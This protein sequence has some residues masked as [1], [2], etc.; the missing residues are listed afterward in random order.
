[1]VTFKTTYPL[2]IVDS[3][4]CWE[5]CNTCA[6]FAL[7]KTDSGT[8]QRLSLVNVVCKQILLSRFL[9]H[10]QNKMLGAFTVCQ[11]DIRSLSAS[12]EYWIIYRGLYCRLWFGW[13]LLLIAYKLYATFVASFVIKADTK[14]LCKFYVYFPKEIKCNRNLSERSPY[15][16]L[17]E[18]NK[19][20]PKLH[21]M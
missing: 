21:R 11:K 9:V 14:C 13:M 1:M 7:I 15:T 6:L 8:V 12:R 5:H 3:L 4:C 17:R 18:I 19:T 10:V 20:F 2:G 16:R